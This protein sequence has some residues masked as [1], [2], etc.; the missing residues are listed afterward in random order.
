MP[1]QPGSTLR[2]RHPGMEHLPAAKRN[3]N[4]APHPPTCALA[5]VRYAAQPAAAMQ[6]QRRCPDTRQDTLAHPCGSQRGRWRT[7]H[8][9]RDKRCP[10]SGSRQPGRANLAFAHTPRQPKLCPPTRLVLVPVPSPSPPA[11]PALRDVDFISLLNLHSLTPSNLR[12][13]SPRL[14]CLTPAARR[15]CIVLRRH[16]LRQPLS[17]RVRWRR[18]DSA[19][20][21]ANHRSFPE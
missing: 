13:E 5:R 6:H 3:E 15:S 17:C 21:G 16:S 4:G 19:A 11:Q 10:A 20:P 14:S 18:R 1:S 9:L 8:H 7:T 2:R 12:L